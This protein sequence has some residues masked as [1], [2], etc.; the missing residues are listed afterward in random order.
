MYFNSSTPTKA[1]PAKPPSWPFL[2]CCPYADH[3]DILA[4]LERES[5][6]PDVARLLPRARALLTGETDSNE[7]P[8]WVK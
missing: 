4:D 7:I 3:A 2:R 6:D 8:W 5:L 1:P